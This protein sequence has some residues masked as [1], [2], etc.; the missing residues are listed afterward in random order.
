MRKLVG[1][2]AGD[3]IMDITKAKFAHKLATGVVYG[4]VALL[5]IGFTVY[6][7]WFAGTALGNP[8]F[9]HRSVRIAIATYFLLFVI[10]ASSWIVGWWKLIQDSR[11]YE[12]VLAQRKGKAGRGQ[13]NGALSV[14]V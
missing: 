3:K 13:S 4:G 12:K 5:V 7:L 1:S 6:A 14:G 2:A 11:K 10:A 9:R 8:W